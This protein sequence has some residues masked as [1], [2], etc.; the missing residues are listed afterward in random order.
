[1]RESPRQ[2]LQLLALDDEPL[3]RNLLGR[4]V[5]ACICYFSEPACHRSIGGVLNPACFM[6]AANGTQK[7]PFR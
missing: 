5:H 7:L 4:G 3:G 6:D 1:M 2:P